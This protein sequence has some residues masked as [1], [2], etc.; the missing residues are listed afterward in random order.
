MEPLDY[1]NYF[2]LLSRNTEFNRIDFLNALYRDFLDYYLND[3]VSL[4]AKA[5]PTYS[6]FNQIVNNYYQKFQSIS[7]TMASL[8]EDNKGLTRN[9]WGYFYC[10]YII[11]LRDKNYPAEARIIYERKRR[12]NQELQDKNYNL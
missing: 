8:R 10:H 9:L 1:C 12:K 3:R 2:G 4:N 5:Y 7:R 6:R 11:P